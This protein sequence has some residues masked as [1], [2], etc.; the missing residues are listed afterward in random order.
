[1]DIRLELLSNEISELICKKLDTL[2]VD[3]DK[4]T[5]TNAIK[6]LSE[7]Q[8]ILKNSD[9]S[10]FYKV[11]CITCVFEKYKLDFGDCHDFI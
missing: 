3:A 5:Q 10:D 7:I 4:I 6:A 11:D 8:N 9:L 2:V 1:M